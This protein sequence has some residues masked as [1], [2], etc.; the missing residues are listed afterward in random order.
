MQTLPTY[1]E[2]ETLRGTQKERGPFCFPRTSFR[3][4][5]KQDVDRSRSTGVLATPAIVASNIKWKLEQRVN[6]GQQYLGQ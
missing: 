2:S 1:F 6:S 4:V 3:A 5:E